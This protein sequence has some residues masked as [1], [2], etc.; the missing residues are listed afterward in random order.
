MSQNL[1]TTHSGT[2]GATDEPAALQVAAAQG[3]AL[4][5]EDWLAVLIGG[6]LIALVAGGLGPVL[7]RFAWGAP[8]AG[9]DAVVGASN[10]ARSASIAG[11][12]LGPLAVG[13]ALLRA[14]MQGFVP[15]VVLLFVLAWFAQLLAGHA[16]ASA[17]GLEYVI[18]ALAIGLAV[19]HA[20]RL[21]DW[22]REAVRTEFYIKTGLV[23]LGATILFDEIVGAGALGI[24]QALIVV[25]TV[26]AFC[27]WLCQRLHV[28]DELA[29]M[30][31][32][33]VS[34]CGVSA[35]IAACGAIQGDR[36]KLSYVTSLVLV[37]AMPMMVL[38]PWIARVTDMSPVVAGAWLGGTLDTSAAVVAAGEMLGASGRN[39]AVVVKLSQNALIGLAAFFLTVWWAMRQ[40]PAAGH[41]TG[42]SGTSLLVIWERFPKF[43]FG[44]LIASLVFSF[45]L[46]DETVKGARGP[47]NGVRT[48]LFAM[49]FV[50]I[51]LET[52]L[53][54][55]VTTGDGRPALA[56]LGGQAFNIAITLIVA[57]V[58]FGGL[59]V[60]VPALG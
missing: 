55:L 59:L 35:A 58:L 53:G 51:G 22:L 32:S 16:T 34:I 38:M 33:A 45:L 13:A 21:P 44:F 2:G 36:K 5:G 25:L 39:A 43:V 27:F 48:T 60:A 54:S 6:V 26:W 52:H 47:V 1:A 42:R 50:S 46:S 37:V 18:F 8:S 3:Q 23:V 4:I 30:L 7:P 41:S 40:Q 17:W 11:L 24:L 29:T 12:V 28:D 57:Y 56:F 31:A 9:L 20:V 19:N 10:L 14:R 15:G 49:A